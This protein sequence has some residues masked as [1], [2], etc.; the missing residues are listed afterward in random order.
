MKNDTEYGKFWTIL[1]KEFKLSKT[2][3]VEIFDYTKLMQNTI[4]LNFEN[5]LISSQQWKRLF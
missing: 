3:C 4:Q 2:L 1:Y 5:I